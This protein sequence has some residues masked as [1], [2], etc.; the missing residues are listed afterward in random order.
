MLL[1]RAGRAVSAVALLVLSVLAAGPVSA[2]PSPSPTR[3]ASSASQPNDESPIS[4]LVKTLAPR[5]LGGP[6]SPLQ[7]AGTLTNRGTAPIGSVR[8]RL[9]VGEAITSR[10][11]LAA[12]DREPAVTFRRG[13]LEQVV[14]L[15]P[16]ASAPFDLRV[17]VR[18]LHLRG[19]GVYPLQVEV[20]GQVGGEGATTQ[21]GLASTYL[22]WFPDR[23][24]KTRIAW[25][26]PVVDAPHHGPR[27]AFLNDDLAASVVTGG[28]L[29]RLLD[30]VRKGSTGACDALA[31]PPPG[32]PP[33]GPAPGCQRE[34]VP[35]TYAV[36]AD[37]LSDVQAIEK[38][39]RVDTEDGRKLE[40][41][42]VA[43][44]A[45]WLAG[46]RQDAFSDRSGVRNDVLALPYA[47]PDVVAVNRRPSLRD[48]VGK[49]QALGQR[50]AEEVL[51]SATMTGV[52]WPPAGPLTPGGLESVVRG[53]TTAVVLD[54]TALPAPLHES[55][56][57]PD[58]RTLLS[59]SLGGVTGLVV[60]STLSDLLSAP[61]GAPG[62]RL[63]E[64]RWLVESAMIAAERPGES[65]TMVVAPVRRASLNSTVVADIVADSGRV[66]WLCP[67]PL[68]DVAGG[69]EA[70]SGQTRVDLP[71]APE[72][73]GQLEPPQDNRDELTVAHLTKVEQV[74]AAATQ[75]TDDVLS[76]S[77]ERT[78]TTKARL[79]RARW[80]TESVAWRSDPRGGQ[81][82]LRAYDADV[83]TLRSMVTVTTGGR[84]LLTSTS[85]TIKVSVQ[86]R[87]DQPVTV[88][89]DLSATNQTRL[90][91]KST[92]PVEV[93]PS[94]SRTVDIKVTA[95][96]SGRF[97]VYAQLLDREGNPFGERKDL[98]V[99]S[100]HY[101]RVALALTG[102][103]AGVLLVAAGVRIVR[104]A[105][106]RGAPG[107]RA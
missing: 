49:A 46:L 60:D 96:T 36:D 88:G 67:V 55:G 11:E 13:A 7:I 69:R 45:G 3:S 32:A 22:P 97:L 29:A 105:L 35:V 16:G 107:G 106:R 85:G 34:A 2:E 80:R 75:F 47:D 4:V 95:L 1:R 25:L 98:V 78:A 33:A 43:A 50:T 38:P 39:Y 104:R 10:S 61:V 99:R 93:G 37:L 40:Q 81:T 53:D 65:R 84:V 31:A 18:D 20:R 41:P 19:L 6:S 48:E 74:R 24:S 101:G 66:P 76:Q 90:T 52:S 26:W 92:P 94:S 9:R 63:A 51:G 103:G 62:T 12:A 64:Q 57:T 17:L 23:P 91:T 87:L 15:A 86:N 68:R 30:G 44:A 73:R 42:S 8:V 71:R 70:C 79:L 82:L 59:S 54:E 5:A 21:V 28:R 14:D 102:L 56:R 72:D 27:E 100:T 77:S 58:A 83:S 89:V